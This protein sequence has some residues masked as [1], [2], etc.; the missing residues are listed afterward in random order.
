M[1]FSVI[2][3]LIFMQHFRWPISYEWI[4]V[5]GIGVFGMIGQI[6]MTRAFQLEEASVLAP[7]KYME[8]IFAL[9]VAYFLFGESYTIFAFLGIILIL[10]GMLMNVFVKDKKTS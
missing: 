8:L 9:I 3:S 5:I 7:F 10:F 1:T 6:F 2:G 4:C